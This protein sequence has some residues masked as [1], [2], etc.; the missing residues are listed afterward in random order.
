MIKR[1]TKD[2]LIKKKL[3]SFYHLCTGNFYQIFENK[4]LFLNV[5]A[6][7]RFVGHLK[8]EYTDY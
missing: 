3:V 4:T 7:F 1:F 8:I 5:E 2:Y 6:N